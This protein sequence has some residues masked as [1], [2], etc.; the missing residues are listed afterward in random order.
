MTSWT[1]TAIPGD[2]I[3]GNI[4]DTVNCELFINL[5]FPESGNTYIKIAS[6]TRTPSAKVIKVKEMG[7]VDTTK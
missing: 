2:V 1:N 6:D 5:D 7:V 3:C 4:Y